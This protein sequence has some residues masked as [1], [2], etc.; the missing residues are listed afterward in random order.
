MES[1]PL[2]SIVTPSYN[3][4]LYIDQN[5]ASVAEQSYGDIEHIIVDG[6]STDGTIQTIQQYEK[7]YNLTWISEPD[8]G[9]YDALEKGF[10]LASGEIFAWLNSDD[11][12]L[13]WAVEIAVENLK[14]EGTEWIIG[15]PANW[16]EAG[17]LNYVNPMRPYYRRG[18]IRKGWYHGEALGWMQQES[19]FWTAELWDKKG[20]FPP[21]VK[22]A[23]DYYLWQQFAERAELKQIGTVIS[24]FRNHENQL[25]SNMEKYRSEIPD[26]GR[27]PRFISALYLQNIYS[28]YHIVREHLR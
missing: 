18:W 25:T 24:G 23:G 5:I 6:G 4:N 21:D 2:V 1:S 12:Y 7:K 3:S 16:D 28:L 14:Q 22:L 8:D 27:L 15:H 26:T 9:M 17:L 10:N 20:G 13:P 19:M 11:M